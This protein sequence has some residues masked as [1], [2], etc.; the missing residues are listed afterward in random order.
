MSGTSTANQSSTDKLLKCEICKQEV[1]IGV[2]ASPL[3]AFSISYGQK[4]LDEGAEPEWAVNAMLE[5]V[6]WDVQGLKLEFVDEVKV[7]VNNEYITVREYAKR[8]L[9]AR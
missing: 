4:C 9:E 1:S 8:K 6:K 2:A 3:G 5:G 7:F